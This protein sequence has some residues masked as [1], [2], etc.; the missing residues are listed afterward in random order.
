MTTLLNCLWILTIFKNH[1]NIDLLGG[2]LTPEDGESTIVFTPKTYSHQ[3][4]FVFVN[5]RQ[6]TVRDA[7]AIQAVMTVSK[8]LRIPK[9]PTSPLP[10]LSPHPLVPSN[11]TLAVVV[12]LNLDASVSSMKNLK[13]YVDCILA[14][15][16]ASNDT[17]EVIIQLTSPGGEVSSYGAA[18]AQF[19]R[20]RN[21]Q[22]ITVTVIVDKVAASGGYLLACLASPSRLFAAPF[23]YTGSIG[24]VGEILNYHR[25]LKDRLSVD[26]IILTAGADKRPLGPASEIT[27]E[28]KEK[29]QGEIGR[30][31]KRASTFN[32][33][34]VQLVAT[35]CAPH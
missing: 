35:F 28:G 18:A 19:S 14:N 20:L 25:L 3:Q 12:P 34:P 27:E 17:T 24:V 16:K 26:N 31:A 1:Y 15:H 21:E 11:S 5:V 9:N 7:A 30:G 2:L 4:R 13:E 8:Q 22:N 10:P 23:S 6:E 32:T 29:T 33:T